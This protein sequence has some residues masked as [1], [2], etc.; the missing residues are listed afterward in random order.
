MTK[1][2]HFINIFF[3]LIS[4]AVFSQDWYTNFDKA[5]TEAKTNNQNIVLVFQGS[6]WCAPC[7]KLEREVWNTKEYQELA[8]DHFVMLKADFPRK[9]ANKLSEDLQKQNAH[10][11]ETYNQEGY[12]PMV[13]VLSQ[14][15]KVLGKIGYDKSTPEAYF[16]KL[17]V[18][19]N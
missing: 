10:L 16:K 3:L 5:K 18:F 17:T 7:I 1:M 4:L 6:D 2:K 12:F 9:K 11:A 19:E 15:G 13:V 8:K 14:E